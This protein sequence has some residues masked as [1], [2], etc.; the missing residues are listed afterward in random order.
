MKGPSADMA[1]KDISQNINIPQEGAGVTVTAYI[2]LFL[3]SRSN[4]P[5]LAATELDVFHLHF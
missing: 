5:V 3:I 4:E 2:P 1:R